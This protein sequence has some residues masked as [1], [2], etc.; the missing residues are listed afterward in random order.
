MEVKNSYLVTEE[1]IREFMKRAMKSLVIYSYVI[2]VAAFIFAAVL[3]N[4]GSRF[5]LGI[6]VACGIVCF[7]SANMIV[8]YTVKEHM[9]Q[10]RSMHG[11][12]KPRTSVIFKEDAI[13]LNEEDDT[14]TRQYDSI[15]RVYETEH[16]WM[17]M[18]GKYVGIPV[19]K[20]S[21][22][23]STEEEFRDLMKKVLPDTVKGKEKL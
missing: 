6:M 23:K 3:Y 12:S 21:F 14:I 8:P 1:V 20:D 19:K 22:K 13:Y 17:L 18:F 16:L 7:I 11:N 10:M 15:D 9:K 5:V 4:T 2:G